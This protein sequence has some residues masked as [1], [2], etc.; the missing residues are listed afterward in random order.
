[1]FVSH[2]WGEFRLMLGIFY[3]D[4]AVKAGFQVFFGDKTGAENE[5]FIL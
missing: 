1:M 2:S 3:G 5:N 4:S